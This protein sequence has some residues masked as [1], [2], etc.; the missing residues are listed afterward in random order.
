MTTYEKHLSEPWFSLVKLKI[1]QVEG[2]LNS[3][4][5]EKMAVGDRILFKNGDM[6]FE[7]TALVEIKKITNYADFRTYLEKETLERCLPGIDSIEDGLGVYYKYYKM[8]DELEH[9]IKALTLK[10]DAP[11]PKRK[12]SRASKK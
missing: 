1:K 2:R 8:R 11:K 10:P 3:G 12:R 6:G 5:F 9:G 4:D 7:R